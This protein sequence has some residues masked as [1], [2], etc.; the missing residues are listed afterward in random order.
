MFFGRK[1]KITSGDTILLDGRYHLGILFLKRRILFFVAIQLGQPTGWVM[2]N[3]LVFWYGII[4]VHQLR[5]CHF[6]RVSKVDAIQNLKFQAISE[7]RRPSQS[8]CPLWHYSCNSNPSWPCARLGNLRNQLASV[9]N[10]RT[11]WEMDV[12]Q[13]GR[14]RGPQML[15]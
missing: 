10:H 5:I 1:S 14:P 4:Y 12:G 15:V 6:C 7:V 13:N 8:A 3:T 9:G 2:T 11:K